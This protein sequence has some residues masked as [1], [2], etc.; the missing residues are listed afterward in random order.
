MTMDKKFIFLT[1][2]VL[3][4]FLIPLTGYADSGKF[5][6]GVRGGLYKSNDADSMILYGGVQARWKL[7]PG[8]SLEGT[9]D[10]RPSESYPGNRKITSTPILAS[11][12]FYLMPG[13]KIS[14]YLLGGVGWY[15]AKIEDSSGSNTT[16]TPGLHLGG[17]LD[18]PLDPNIVF[19]ADIRYFFLDYGDQKVKN[20]NTN[21][22]IISAGVTFYLW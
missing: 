17:G 20:I 22:Y 1:A 7:F 14:P 8:M 3:T 19:N 13:G 12:L 2:I 21:G 15:Y 6:L 10:Y 5:G 11:A 4:L 9:F 16:Y 18:I